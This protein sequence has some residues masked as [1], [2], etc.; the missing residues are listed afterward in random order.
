MVAQAEL[1]NKLQ[2][3]DKHLE[4]QRPLSDEEDVYSAGVGAGG[5]FTVN[6]NAV[7]PENVFFTPGKTY[8]VRTRYSNLSGMYILYFWS[9]I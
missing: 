2:E 3:L 4:S 7:M 9:L 5:T 8:E 6:E 1:A